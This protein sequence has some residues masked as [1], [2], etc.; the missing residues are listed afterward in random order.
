MRMHGHLSHPGLPH[1]EDLRREV[2]DPYHGVGVLDVGRLSV[3]FAHF[4][5][6][7]VLELASREATA[8]R[9]TI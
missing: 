7:S 1:R 8:S 4:R 6:L 5:I 2:I 3:G 9:K